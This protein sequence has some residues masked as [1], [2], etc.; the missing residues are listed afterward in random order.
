MTMTPNEREESIGESGTPSRAVGCYRDHPDASEYCY[1]DGSAWRQDV[2]AAL[3]RTHRPASLRGALA[4]IGE[5]V[6]SDE[7][8]EC[9]A[10]GNYYALRKGN[11]TVTVVLTDRRLLFFFG[12]RRFARV[13]DYL[14]ESVSFVEYGWGGI[15]V[16]AVGKRLRINQM[17]HKDAHEIVYA[18]RRHIGQPTV[19]VPSWRR[20]LPPQRRR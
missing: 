2:S 12:G 5:F 6:P 8:V 19:E 20:W 9:M 17:N 18:T 1:S 3:N 4:R 16:F 11:Q 10:S 7:T 13:R 14:L 15:A